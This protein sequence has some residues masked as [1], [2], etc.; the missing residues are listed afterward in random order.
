MS[1]KELPSNDELRDDTNIDS[2]EVHVEENSVNTENQE[3][4]IDPVLKLE[5]EVKDLKDQNLR[6]YAEFENFRRRSA[7]ERLELMESANKDTLAALLTILDDFDRA[8]KNTEETEENILVLEGMKLIQ[9]KLTDTLKNK[10]LIAME[11]SIGKAFNVEEMEA[12]TQIPAPTPDMA[13]KVMD[14]VEK[15]Y[16]IGE[17][18]LRYSKV[19]VGK[20]A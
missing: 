11:S 9:H 4:T 18:V 14:E 15:G 5:E 10:G 1:E 16:K 2:Q 8:L 12:I 13:G 7:K 20:E 17:K 3:T 6:L 19:V